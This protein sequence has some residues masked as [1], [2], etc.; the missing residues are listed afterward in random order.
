MVV[1][2][3][4]SEE[5]DNGVSNDIEALFGDSSDGEVAVPAM[6][7]EQVALLA[8]FRTAHREQVMC[9]FM[10][11]KRKALAA[12]IVVCDNAAREAACMEAEEDAARVAKKAVAPKE[13]TWAEEIA[14]KEA[15]EAAAREMA[16]DHRRW[17]EDM[18]AVQRAREIH[19]LASERCHRLR[20]ARRQ[21]HRAR[22]ND[23]KGSNDVNVGWGDALM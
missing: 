15:A 17:D 22:Q 18:M 5:E 7:N 8:L 21:A 16:R 19:E 1:P 6:M 4:P 23:G 20:L 13:A 12:M 11:V 9:Q 14:E 2:H 10:V 3:E